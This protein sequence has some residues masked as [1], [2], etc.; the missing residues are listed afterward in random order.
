M[1]VA[2]ITTS[3]SGLGPQPSL[4]LVVRNFAGGFSNKV[5]PTTTVGLFNDFTTGS[6]TDKVLP[7]I[8]QK[9]EEAEKQGNFTAEMAWSMV[10]WQV[11]GKDKKDKGEDNSEGETQDSN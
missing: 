7:S 5:A 6:E 3:T 2:A 9:I 10:L 8:R 1:P 4:R 11:E